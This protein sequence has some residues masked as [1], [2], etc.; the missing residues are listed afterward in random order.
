MGP[1]WIQSH[2]LFFGCNLLQ[3]AHEHWWYNVWLCWV[4][5]FG[6]NV[7]HLLSVT[8][9]CIWSLLLFG[10]L[11]HILASQHAANHNH[12]D[13]IW[14]LGDVTFCLVA[15]TLAQID[16]KKPV[17]LHY[18][19]PRLLIFT[20]TFVQKCLN[21]PPANPFHTVEIIQPQPVFECIQS[22]CNHHLPFQGFISNWFETVL[23]QDHGLMLLL[24]KASHPCFLPLV[25]S[26]A[27]SLPH[28]FAKLFQEEFSLRQADWQIAFYTA[29]VGQIVALTSSIIIIV[30][31]LRQLRPGNNPHCIR[32]P[33][34]CSWLESSHWEANWG[35]PWYAER[36]FRLMIRA[37]RCRPIDWM[38]FPLSWTHYLCCWWWQ[39]MSWTLWRREHWRPDIM[40]LVEGNSL[41]IWSIAWIS[42]ACTG[43]WLQTVSCWMLSANGPAV[44]LEAAPGK[45]GNHPDAADDID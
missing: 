18:I 5:I 6:D 28:C 26:T 13:C 22:I 4:S 27:V 12:E 43:G 17:A 20:C 32:F 40:T 16:H 45:T 2:M 35:S 36:K 44:H 23:P 7:S 8:H 41:P 38:V 3:S 42:L 14:Q 10:S 15:C 24:Q 34:F 39:P 33:W 21:P 25:E 37:G 30:R 1:V 11:N 9:I 19:F 29:E 31:N